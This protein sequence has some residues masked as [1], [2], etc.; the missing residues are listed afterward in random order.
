MTNCP[1]LKKTTTKKHSRLKKD[2]MMIVVF[3]CLVGKLDIGCVCVEGSNKVITREEA[4]KVFSETKVSFS[5][6]CFILN[7]FY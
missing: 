4:E 3:F 1:H 7:R 6:I 2:P 5:Q